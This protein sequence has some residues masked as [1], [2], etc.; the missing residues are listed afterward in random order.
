MVLAGIMLAMFMAAVE[1]TVVATAMPSVIAT[2]GGVALYGWVS[3]SYLLAST[4]TVPI[5][6]K[7]SDLRGR[8]PVILGGI[9]L[10]LI[11]SIA[12][13]A[14]PTTELLIVARVLQGLG[15]GAIQPIAMTMV[16]DLYSIEER[17]KIQAWLGSVWAIA[18][19]LGPLLGG[20]FVDVLS[21]RWV[22]WFNVPFGLASAFI[23]AKYFKDPEHEATDLELD[24]T[25]AVLLSA[26]SVAILL[27]T[28]G[29]STTVM[30]AI[31]VVGTAVFVWHERRAPST[32]IPFALFK[33]A[34]IAISMMLSALVGAIMLGVLTYAPLY[35][36]GVLQRTP[37]EAGSVV[38][39][40]LIGWPLA[41]YITGRLLKRVG[42]RGPVVLGSA[43]ILGGALLIAF[44][45]PQTSSTWPWWVGTFVLG[46]G[47]GT[48]VLC[49]TVSLQSS[50]AYRERGSITALLMFT[51]SMGMAF[52]VGALGAL[53]TARL[54][55]SI[56]PEEISKL[57]AHGQRTSAAHSVTADVLAASIYPLL[58]VVAALAF[59]N[60]CIALVYRPK[61]A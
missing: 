6:G 33:K 8:R 54:A 42:F 18:G 31:A 11:G 56:D 27:F 28:E 24:W 4:V 12:S 35:V 16:G 57:L 37:A 60:L 41:S 30:F 1:A 59:V 2:L 61:T 15:A 58:W 23:L 21:W 9:A 22:F 47:M 38:T 45:V 49:V 48:S 25:G 36:Q 7:L 20:F 34:H 40:L 17:G 50:V 3:A 53:L 39:P 32:I 13:G 55:G 51:R 46:A 52:S 5:Y 43:L 29:R 26:I 10:F 14:A 19:A 44:A